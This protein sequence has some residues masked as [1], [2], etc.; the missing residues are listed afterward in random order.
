MFGI[1]TPATPV[2]YEAD[3]VALA[4]G[5]PVEGLHSVGRNGE[6]A[7]VLIEDVYLRTRQK[8]LAD[9]LGAA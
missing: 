8:T 2:E 6:F 3:R 5:L 4:L 7:R 1:I 9:V